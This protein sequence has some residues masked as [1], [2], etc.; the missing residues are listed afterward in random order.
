MSFYFTKIAKLSNKISIFGNG[1]KECLKAISLFCKI[2][3]IFRKFLKLYKYNVACPSSGCEVQ[4][5]MGLNDGEETMEASSSAF[6][7]ATVEALIGAGCAVQAR[8]V[9]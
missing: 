3:R 9:T 6:T 2:P 7:V 5:M 1:T 8:G 4:F